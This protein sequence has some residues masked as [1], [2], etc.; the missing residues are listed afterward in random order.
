VVKIQLNISINGLKKSGKIQLN[1]STYRFKK[2]GKIQL[3]IST[4]RLKKSGQNS[5]KYLNKWAQNTTKSNLFSDTL[6]Y[7]Q[8]TAALTHTRH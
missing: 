7:F 2:S 1:I 6:F 3:N 8:R 4:Y 5:I